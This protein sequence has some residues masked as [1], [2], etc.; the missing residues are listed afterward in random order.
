MGIPPLDLAVDASILVAEALRKRG[1]ALLADPL[2]RL[3][4]AAEAWSE[5]EHELRGRVALLVT[6]GHLTVEE[7]NALLTDSLTALTTRLRI[8]PPESYAVHLGEAR[9]RLPRDPL[10]APTA[11]LAIALGCGVWTNDQ[12]FFGCGLPVWTT[13]SLQRYLG[14]LRRVDEA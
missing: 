5:T 10:D 8:V 7:A 13:E 9:E 11:A 6:R 2:L 3:H 14:H 1:R 4:V 12:D